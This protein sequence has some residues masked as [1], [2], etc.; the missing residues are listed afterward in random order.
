MKNFN[1][2]HAKQSKF[3]FDELRKACK[4]DDQYDVNSIAIKQVEQDYGT[5]I[6]EVMDS[7]N[8]GP[9]MN[10]L[11]TLGLRCVE[12][13]D[14]Y[15]SFPVFRFYDYRPSVKCYDCQANPNF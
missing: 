14:Q 9:I 1:E 13:K 10:Y 15:I 6:H 8:V 11:G 4:P 3:V 5:S 2:M 12:C 7:Q